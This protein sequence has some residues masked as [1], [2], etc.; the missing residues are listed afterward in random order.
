MHKV[1]IHVMGIAAFVFAHVHSAK[2]P[3]NSTDTFKSF[4]E[5]RLIETLL[6]PKD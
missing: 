4:K 6:G 3:S 2:D 5:R 1:T